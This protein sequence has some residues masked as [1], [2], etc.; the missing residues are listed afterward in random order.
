MGKWRHGRNREAEK[1]RNGRKEE[2]MEIETRLNIVDGEMKLL[3]VVY[4]LIL[5]FLEL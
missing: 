3:G 2:K 4:C 1:W 5:R